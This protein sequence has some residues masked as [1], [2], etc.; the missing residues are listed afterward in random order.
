MWK[1]SCLVLILAAA[2]SAGSQTAPMIIIDH[3]TI[4]DGTGSPP[5]KNGA[6][7]IQGDRI[8]QIGTRGTIK[9]G[10]GTTVIDATGKFVIPGLIDA[11]V[12]FDQ[13]GDV[14]TRPDA[15]DLRKVRP[16]A[17]E[18]A[19]T[20][21]RLPVT[22]M[23]YISS[24][25]TSVV[26]MGG[27]LWT[28]EV[29]DI[30]NRTSEAPRV[31]VAGPLISTL[32]EGSFAESDPPVIVAMTPEA[33]RD[34]VR[35]NAERHPDLTKIL[36]IRGAGDI[37]QQFAV[38]KAA[39]EE[40]H[41]R[42]IRVAVH[43][44][45]LET[46]K[47]ALRAGADILVHS[48]EDRRIDREFIDLAKGRNVLYITTLIVNEGY[49]EVFG[50]SV[51][52]TDIEQQFGDP[53]VIATWS[54]LAKTPSNEIPGGVPAPNL[55][56]MTQQTQFMNLQLLDSTGVRI[57]AGSDAGNIG[58]LHGPALHREFELMAEAGM[59]PA[60]ILVA[61]TRNA[62]AVMGREADLGTLA[63]GKLADLLIL[64]ADPTRDVHNFRKIYKVMKNGVFINISPD[65]LK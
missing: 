47:L 49:D 46:A 63:K 4:V 17:E 52:L 40:S 41:A 38:V 37:D 7:V 25:V 11:H 8:Q 57:V 30:A 29:R 65:L 53:Q 54:Q 50:Q 48:V 18:L 32:S 13:S 12:H 33:A 31:A 16:Y 19:W 45:E 5:I 26:D 34:L 6:I 14:F 2:L 3:P 59:R 28:Y 22:L 51:K 60:D 55:R 15:V 1:T 62:A 9:P 58:T 39:A 43:A 35:K 24:G 64:D 23:R 10:P 61:A 36:F 27:P 42:G 56:D 21:Q 20:K 44:T